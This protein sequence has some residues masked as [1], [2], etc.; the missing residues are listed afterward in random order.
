[1]SSWDLRRKKCRECDFLVKK[2]VGV[3]LPSKFT[4]TLL[5][6]IK[7]ILFVCAYSIVSKDGTF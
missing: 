7:I 2:L 1:M 6:V 5:N 3:H 4:C